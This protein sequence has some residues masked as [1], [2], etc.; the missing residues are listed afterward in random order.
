MQ[1]WR[2]APAWVG[3]RDS[4][5]GGWSSE[6]EREGHRRAAEWLRPDLQV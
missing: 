3:E 6:K 2:W 4:W 1:A 5:P